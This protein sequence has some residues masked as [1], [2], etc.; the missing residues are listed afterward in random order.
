MPHVEYDVD[1]TLPPDRARAALI[2]FSDRRPDIWTG[3][4]RSLY[5]VYEVGE[6][7]AEIREGTKM[8]GMKLWARERYDWSE[9]NTVRWTVVDSNFSAPGSRLIASL[10]PT[11][12]G[13]TRIHVD[14]ERTPSSFVGRVVMFLIVATKGRPLAA[15]MQK[16][17][18]A[19]ETEPGSPA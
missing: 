1:T 5:E 15:S 3:I 13:G 10:S 18:N 16:A 9:P 2:D 17:L 8:P 4:E 19:L 6:T 12:A 11:D 7:W 14:W